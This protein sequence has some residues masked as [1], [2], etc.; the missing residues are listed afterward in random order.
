VEAGGHLD[1]LEH[2]Q[3]ASSFLPWTAQ[4]SQENR[5]TGNKGGPGP[6]L[7]AQH[8][9]EHHEVVEDD[10]GTR[11]VGFATASVGRPPPARFLGR[12]FCGSSS[13]P[14]VD[15]VMLSSILALG[16]G[17]IIVGGPSGPPFRWGAHDAAFF[18]RA[19]AEAIASLWK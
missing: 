18:A 12:L 8:P 14:S 17:G 2:S 11:A 5:S 13:R 15:P 19:F 4:R 7:P 16:G 10:L 1:H 9:L 3:G 6:H